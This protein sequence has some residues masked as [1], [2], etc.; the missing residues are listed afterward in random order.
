MLCGG[1][2]IFFSADERARTTPGDSRQEQR[3]AEKVR[4]AERT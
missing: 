2:K 4:R 3:A 1:E